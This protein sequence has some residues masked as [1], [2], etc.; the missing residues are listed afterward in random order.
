MSRELWG[1]LA[2]PK[3][4]DDNELL[5]HFW[6]LFAELLNPTTF[7]MTSVRSSGGQALILAERWSALSSR[8][9]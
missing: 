7:R 3:K 5:C 9:D 1:T 2:N 8:W 4:A 6:A